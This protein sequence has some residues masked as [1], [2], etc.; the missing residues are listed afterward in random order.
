[1]SVFDV[2]IRLCA[3]SAAYSGTL[4]AGIIV[5]KAHINISQKCVLA[6]F[7]RKERISSHGMTKAGLYMSELSSSCWTNRRWICDIFFFQ[8][9]WRVMAK[10]ALKQM[11]IYGKEAGNREQE[12][13]RQHHTLPSKININE[14][15]C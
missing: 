9:Y 12:I 13:D 14:S 4:C 11:L 6:Y 10:I 7:C 2:K 8:I 3:H 1:M 5:E 15:L